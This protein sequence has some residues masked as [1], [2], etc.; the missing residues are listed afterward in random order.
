MNA[1]NDRRPKLPEDRNENARAE[2]ALAFIEGPDNNSLSEGRSSV[3]VAEPCKSTSR[4]SKIIEAAKGFL[5]NH[6]YE[7]YDDAYS[8]DS[9]VHFVCKN[10]KGTIVFV[11]CDDDLDHENIDREQFEWAAIAFIERHPEIEPTPIRFDTV[12]VQPIGGM[13]LA[14]HHINCIN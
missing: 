13:A 2:Q 12:S 5:V 10:E 7:I 6:G 14:R 3:L 1:S 4:A 8:I 9:Y 11:H